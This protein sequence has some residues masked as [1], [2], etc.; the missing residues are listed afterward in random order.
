MASEIN[1]SCT[2]GSSVDVNEQDRSGQTKLHRAC[3]ANRVDEVKMLMKNPY[4]NPNIIDSKGLTALHRACINS[5]IEVVTLL[6]NHPQL[7]IHMNSVD[8]RTVEDLVEDIFH[9]RLKAA[10]KGLKKSRRSIKRKL[11]KEKRKMEKRQALLQTENDLH[12][13][14]MSAELARLRTENK[15]LVKE[16]DKFKEKYSQCISEKKRLRLLFDEITQESFTGHAPLDKTADKRKSSGL[17][18]SADDMSESKLQTQVRQLRIEQEILR[19]NYKSQKLEI[20][21]LKDEVKDNWDSAYVRGECLPRETCG[22]TSMKLAETA[23]ALVRAQEQILEAQRELEIC[24]VCLEFPKSSAIDPCGHQF[25]DG[26]LNK[27]PTDLCFKCRGTIT[28]RL[29]LY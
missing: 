6:L 7:K 22:L 28:K 26:C 2:N 24:S 3:I 25:C 12:V 18:T 8:G 19:E 1:H 23:S 16:R 11:E 15:R 13:K 9:N 14:A 5:N 10:S 20:S 17:K 27:N 29:R 4:V 21:K